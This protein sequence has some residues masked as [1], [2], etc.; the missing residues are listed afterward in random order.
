VTRAPATGRARPGDRTH[1]VLGGES[2]WSIASDHL[3]SHASTARI[4]K[5]VKRLWQLNRE[6]ISTG[7]PNLLMPGTR[8]KLR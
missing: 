7:D 1:V 4:A 3:G 2:L 5:E 6:R 8:L